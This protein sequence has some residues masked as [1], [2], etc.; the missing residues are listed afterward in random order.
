MKILYYLFDINVAF[1][2]KL[3]SNSFVLLITYNL[4]DIYKKRLN[5]KL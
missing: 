4:N 5:N 2:S 1:N 3:F